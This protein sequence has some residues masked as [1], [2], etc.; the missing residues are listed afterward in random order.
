MKNVMTILGAILFA[1]TILTSCGGG[2]KK[3]NEINLKPISSSIKGELSEYFN[4]VEGTYKLTGDDKYSGTDNYQLKVQFSRTDKAFDF[5]VNSVLN[6]VGGF[7][8]YCDLLDEQTA[9]V[10]QADR[11][12]MITQG[13]SDGIES[14]ASLKSGETGWVTYHF[15]GS[16]EVIEKIKSFSVDSKS[17]KDLQRVSSSTSSEST[18][19]SS[20]TSSVDCDQFIKDYSAF[21]D[22]YV[23]L[24]KKYKA[25]QSDP[26]ILNEYTEAAQK[27]MDM[28]KD[29]SSC[30]DPAYASKLM[31]IANKIAKAAI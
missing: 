26:S 12:G 15:S 13:S 8:L 24:M 11:G 30:T 18:D 3:P 14:L 10:I 20:S 1:T 23:K 6:I 19:N 4:I 21:A 22:S 7:A 2:E 28:Q 17:G 29:A 16:P 31:E 9:P 25:N 27:A 5:D